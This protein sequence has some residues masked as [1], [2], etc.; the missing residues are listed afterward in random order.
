MRV[1]FV[2][3]GP[4]DPE[5]LTLKGKRL[6]EEAD[7]VIYAGSL[8]NP[9]LLNYARP[10]I[11][12]YDS[13]SM[14]LE[15]VLEVYDSRAAEEGLILRLHTGD[16]AVYGAIQ[17]QLDHCAA[18]GIPTEVV[19]GVSSVFAAA[20]AL[21][22]ELTLPGLSQTVILTRAAGRTPVPEAERLAS[23][24][25]HGTTMAIFLSATLLEEVVAEVLPSYGAACPVRVVH[26]ASWPDQRIIE[27]TLGDIGEKA[28]GLGGQAM[29]L[30]GPVLAPSGYDRSKLYDPDFTHGRRE[31]KCE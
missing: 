4:G 9:A 5:L 25:S 29:I 18:R 6:L 27:G 21:Q 16:P 7:L 1:A 15:E 13:A 24:A 2:G 19:P 30:L 31:G 12:T 11:P 28:A 22:R 14:T 26:R 20:A 23:L 3:A 10:G 17:E 8:V